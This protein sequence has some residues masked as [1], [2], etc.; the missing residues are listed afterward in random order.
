MR[1]T[2]IKKYRKSKIKN[3][4]I[5]DKYPKGYINNHMKKL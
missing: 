1:H 4:H 5:S 2:K 3:K